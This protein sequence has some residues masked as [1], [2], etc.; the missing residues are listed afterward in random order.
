M[1]RAEL[2]S[3]EAIGSSHRMSLGSLHQRPG[4][5]HALLLPAGELVAPLI[6][7]VGQ[8]QFVQKLKRPLLF[9]LGV[10]VRR[11]REGGLMPQ[12]PVQHVFDDAEPVDQVVVLKDHAR[13]GAD[14]AQLAP[15]DLRDVLP[16]QN[17]R[18]LRCIHQTVDATQERGLAGA[19]RADDGDELAFLNRERDVTQGMGGPVGLMHVS[20]FQKCQARHS[21][22]ITRVRG[23]GYTRR[24]RPS[25]SAPCRSS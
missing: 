8:P 25:G 15:S 22:P 5:A 20:H 10:P 7:L 6:G 4:D 2:G 3:S 18:T 21:N 9:A 11:A 23:W 16:V 14:M 12:P 17:D 19:P 24:R 13:L 1:T